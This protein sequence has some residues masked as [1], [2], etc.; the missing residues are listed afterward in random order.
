MPLASMSKVTSTCGTPRGAGGMPTRSNWPSILFWAA[1]SRSPWKTRMV[2]AVWLSS[3]VEKVW[4]FFVGIVVLRSI[5]RV[6]TPP[7]VSMPSDS[8]VTSSSRTS[9]TS[10]FST[11]AWTAAPTATTSSGLTLRAGSLPKNCFTTSMTFGMRVMPPTRMTSSIW[12]AC[13]PASLSAARQGSSVRCTRSSTSVSSLARDSLITRCFGP[14]GV[15]GDERQVDLGLLGVGELDLGLLGR[16]L[17]ALQGEL[18]VAQVDALLLFELVREVADDALVEVL[19]AEEGVAV[20]RLDLEHAVADLEDRHVERAAAQVIDRDDAALA[21]VHAVGERRRGRLVDD[22]QDLEAGDAA[23]ILG[24][25]ALGVVEV[26]RNGDDRLLDLLAEIG[27]G[28]LLHLAE[29]E[30]RDLAR[31]VLLAVRLDPGV[32]A[33]RLHDLE[34][35]ER[36]FL[37]DHRVVEAAP[38]QALDRVE[39]LHRIGDRLTLGGLADEPLAGVGEGDHRRGRPRAFGILDDLGVAAFHDRDA[40]IGRT[41]VDTDDFR[42]DC[43]SLFPADRPG[44]K[45]ARFDPRICVYLPEKPGQDRGYIGPVGR[46]QWC[47]LTGTAKFSPSGYH[48]GIGAA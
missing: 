5:R 40:G 28:G 35:N 4:L 45:G 30:G 42:H 15:G 38:D 18:V 33:R 17:Q 12:P 47:R 3:A 41:E 2:T 27:L 6:N 36:L 10:P 25:L 7:S 20:G 16:F 21:L 26:G 13:R 34:G 29:D 11:A 8:G 46:L 39:G 48:I 24:R 19:A 32:A 1:I 37:R 44:P 14:A 9:L 22:A 23:G 31:A 43:Y